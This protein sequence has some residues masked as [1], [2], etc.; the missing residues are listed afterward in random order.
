[1]PPEVLAKV[2][3]SLIY[4]AGRK[5][6]AVARFLPVVFVMKTVFVKN[7]IQLIFPT[8]KTGLF[9]TESEQN[10]RRRLAIS[11]MTGFIV[12]PAINYPCLIPK[13]TYQTILDRLKVSER[14]LVF[15]VIALKTVMSAMLSEA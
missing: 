4:L 13:T 1:M 7:V 5:T 8:Q 14:K 10:A 15:V 3:L 11:A 6:T 9:S 12:N 2:E